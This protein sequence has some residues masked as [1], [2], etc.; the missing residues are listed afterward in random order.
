[1]GD[2]A[3]PFPP[4][5]PNPP[6]STGFLAVKAPNPRM[7]ILPIVTSKPAAAKAPAA[8][9]LAA[10]PHS[11]KPVARGA[12]PAMAPLRGNHF[13]FILTLTLSLSFLA[14]YVET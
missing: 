12:P 6:L 4:P 13:I 11:S 2:G 1:M 7:S 3:F 10:N 14:W 9:A 5:P 8:K